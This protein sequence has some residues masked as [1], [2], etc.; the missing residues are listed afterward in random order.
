MKGF[1]FRRA[2]RD[3]G[4]NLFS[5]KGKSPLE[6]NS[7]AL[8]R[9]WS[10]CVVLK[11]LWSF[12]ESAVPL[13]GPA[14]IKNGKSSLQ[15]SSNAGD[16]C[17]GNFQS[18][19][20]LT[21][22]SAQ[23]NGVYSTDASVTLPLQLRTKF[24]LKRTEFLQVT[25]CA[26]TLLVDAQLSS[27]V[28]IWVSVTPKEG[29]WKSGVSWLPAGLGSGRCRVWG[30]NVTRASRSLLGVETGLLCSCGGGLE[31]NVLLNSAGPGLRC[32]LICICV[33]LCIVYKWLIFFPFRMS[34]GTLCCYLFIHACF[35][36]CFFPFPS[37]LDL[38]SSEGRACSLLF[39]LHVFPRYKSRQHFRKVSEKWR[40]HRRLC[41]SVPFPSSLAQSCGVDDKVERAKMT[42]LR[43]VWSGT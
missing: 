13:L 7:D 43:H 1:C 39:C 14:N 33:L 16:R 5:V 12:V 20:K 40:M 26:I 38:S 25:P 4:E 29:G 2:R 6:Q 36:P 42:H 28:N 27:Q 22:H 8:E 34:Y 24:V 19:N 15:R 17:A 11:R 32:A 41:I 10:F 37:P 21:L 3:A 35:F 31:W 18:S 9:L 30:A 23:V